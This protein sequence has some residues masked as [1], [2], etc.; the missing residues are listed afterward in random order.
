MEKGKDKS[1]VDTIWNFMAS[2]K[3]AIILFAFIGFSSI[4]G[5]V[6]EQ[7]AEPAKN[8]KVIGSLFGDSMAPTLFN[9]FER[10]GFMD[11][12]SSWWFMAFLLMFAANLFICSVDRFP[13]IW[14]MAKSPIKP[15][16][17]ERLSAIPLRRTLRVQGKPG[18]VMQAV[19][20]ASRATGVKVREAEHEGK[21]QFVGESHRFSRLGVFVTH[22][23]IIVILLGAIIGIFFGF[24]G[25]M[26][27]PEGATYNIAYGRRA[28]PVTTQAEAEERRIII[29]ALGTAGDTY[30]AASRLGVDAPRLLKRMKRYGIEPIGFGLRLD[31]FDVDFYGQSDMAKEYSSLLTVIDG[32]KEVLQKRIEVNDPLKYNGYTFYQSSYGMLQEARNYRF[33]VRATSSAGASETFTL[34][35]GQSFTVPGTDTVAVVTEFIPALSFDSSGKPFNYTKMMNNPAIRLN[36]K[37]G[38]VAYSKWI[39]KRYPDTWTLT[40]GHVIALTDVW[41]AQYTGLQVRKDPGVWIVYLGCL[42]MSIGLYVAFFM[43]HK[44]VWI[45]LKPGKGGTEVTI[46]ASTNKN[47]EALQRKLDKMVARLGAG[48]Q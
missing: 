26:N 25:F 35:T 18:D 13:R 38:Q 23:S 34:R 24:K 39:L 20:R 40:S 15:L 27:L 42:L 32:G 22:T 21:T 16:S 12:Y 8:L 3:L 36:I 43:S 45:L 6:I 44:K 10:L 41:G 29:T 33:M 31:D 30:S 14:K 5:T 47:R 2:V 9:V 7:N 1:L 19:A 4:I 17:P 46:A 28:A 37:E 48:G 11:M